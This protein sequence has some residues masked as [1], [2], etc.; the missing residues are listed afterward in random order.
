MFV[1]KNVALHC[2]LKTSKLLNQVAKYGD[3]SFDPFEAL[4]RLDA[5]VSDLK[6]VFRFEGREATLPTADIS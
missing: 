3:R 2:R 4:F 6:L 1:M 5:G